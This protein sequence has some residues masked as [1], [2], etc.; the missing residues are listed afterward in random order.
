V[1]IAKDADADLVD[2]G[3]F[4]GF[5]L[6]VSNA[7]PGEAKDVV[8]T[9]VLPGSFS[10]GVDTATSDL[11]E[12]ASCS[13][14]DGVLSCQLGDLPAG[15]GVQA[16][17][18]VIAQ[19][20]VPTGD[21]GRGVCGPY[22]NVAAVTPAN[23]D[24]AV[25]NVVDLEVRCPIGIDLTKTGPTLAH[26][27]DTVTYEFTATNAGYVDLV[28]V[29]LVDPI[30][31]GSPVLI[32]K[33]DGDAIF[34]I[35]L[36]SSQA[37]L[38]REVWTYRCTRVVRAT[39]P[40]PL[41][42][43]ALV[44]GTDA[45]QR[46]TTDTASWLVDLIHPA[47]SIVK[48]AGPESISVSG[49]VTYT[50]VITNT[51]DTTLFNLLVTDDILGAIATLGQ[52]GVGESVTFAK[53]VDVNAL[54]PPRNIG[55]AVGTDQLGLTVSASDDAV[56]TV[57]LGAVLELPRTGAPL[58]AQTRAALALIQVGIVLTLAGRRRR[59]GRWAD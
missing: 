5:M 56:I 17:I 47:I 2:A 25:S 31:D 19:S 41:P 57:V 58:G 45:D 24:G 16:R 12:G 49:S 36:D 27:G 55:T 14:D 23:G 37:G 51:G 50:Y 6:E 26:I 59:A 35:D 11:P 4:I 29:K 44:T 15:G 52:L 28:D 42:N 3:G 7:G 1:N 53:T 22:S 10:W 21:A 46:T 34:E 32:S 39:D 43:T 13:V 9:D 40:D 38:Q 18:H 8:V 48:T 54:T 20:S 33:G 30:C